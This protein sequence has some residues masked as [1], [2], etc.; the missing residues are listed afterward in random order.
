MN[1]SNCCKL[2]HGANLILGQKVDTDEISQIYQEELEIDL[3]TIGCLPPEK[4][5]ALATCLDCGLLQFLPDWIGSSELYEKLQRFSW[6]YQESK[7]EFEIAKKFIEPGFDVIEIGCGNG[8]FYTHLPE[9]VRYI[10]LEFNRQAVTDAC[11][12]GIDVQSIPLAKIA[13]E[14]AGEFDVACAFQLLEHVPDPRG[15]LEDMTRVIRKGGLLMFSVPAEDSFLRYEVNNVTNLPP[16]H[17]TRWP[18]TTLGRVASLLDLEVVS[19]SHEP[20]AP[21][22]RRAYANATIWRALSK[23]TPWGH[24]KVE[25]NALSVLPRLAIVLA[26]LPIRIWSLWNCSSLHGHTI[27]F[28]ARKL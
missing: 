11:A 6:Y 18:D 9:N 14:Q 16:H 28:V 19:I 26:G 15:F 7:S 20:L 3:A 23:L 13:V 5:I 2:C 21:G 10:G 1:S 27:T 22:H 12:K 17:A 4:Y 8:N 24:S 25:I